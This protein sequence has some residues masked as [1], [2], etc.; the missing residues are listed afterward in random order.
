MARFGRGCGG[1]EFVVVVQ[2]ASQVVE[3]QSVVDGFNHFLGRSAEG[4]VV[5]NACDGDIGVGACNVPSL[6]GCDDNCFYE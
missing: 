2:Y 1:D 5:D 4:S 3:G 6:N